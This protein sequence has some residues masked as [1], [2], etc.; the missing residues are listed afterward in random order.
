MSPSKATCDFPNAVIE[1]LECLRVHVRDVHPA[2]LVRASEER[3]DIY[4][5]GQAKN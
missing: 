2:R 4:Y 3:T 5:E 1:N